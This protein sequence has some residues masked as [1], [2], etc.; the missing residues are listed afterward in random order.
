M[1]CI[2]FGPYCLGLETSSEFLAGLL[3]IKFE[4]HITNGEP[5]LAFEVVLDESTPAVSVRE[6]SISQLNDISISGR[7]FAFVQDMITGEFKN[8]R[9]S[10]LVVKKEAFEKY[11]CSLFDIFLTRCFY[12]LERRSGSNGLS[13][14]ISHASAVKRNGKGFLF[15]AP[16]ETGKTTVASLLDSGT[17][18][19]Q[20]C[21]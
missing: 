4:K 18:R 1:L 13:R 12:H 8:A 7:R 21:S 2:Q 6:I 10:R 19:G 3:S 14:A 15:P 17:K 5:D 16:S 11:W 9:E 20:V